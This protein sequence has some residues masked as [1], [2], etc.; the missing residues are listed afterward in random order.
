MG[1]EKRGTVEVRTVAL[2]RCLHGDLQCLVQSVLVVTVMA[3]LLRDA[4]LTN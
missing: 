2:A 3:E 1:L 4:L